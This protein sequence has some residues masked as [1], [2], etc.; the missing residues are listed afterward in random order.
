MALRD[1]M[2]I[3][4]IRVLGIYFAG[5]GIAS[6]KFENHLDRIENKANIIAATVAAA[7]AEL[8]RVAVV[9]DMRRPYPPEIWKPCQMTF[10][11]GALQL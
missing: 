9:Q 1:D 7:P 8:D 3:V 2:R 5:W 4:P 11:F 6:Q 10:E